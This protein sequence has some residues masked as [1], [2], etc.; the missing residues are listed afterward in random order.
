MIEYEAEYE[1]E[2]I[3]KSQN[4]ESITVPRPPRHCCWLSA[5]KDEAPLLSGRNCMLPLPLPP[6]RVLSTGISPFSYGDS[7]I[8]RL[9]PGSGGQSYS[10]KV[11]PL[12]N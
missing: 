11:T 4:L 6:A 1:Y 9:P 7:N 10:Y 12:R 5:A 2:W 3:R 8:E